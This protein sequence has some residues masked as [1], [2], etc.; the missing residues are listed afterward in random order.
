M[1]SPAILTVPQGGRHHSSHFTD[2]ET[3]KLGILLQVSQ[4]E[5]GKFKLFILESIVITTVWFC[6]SW[7]YLGHHRFWCRSSLNVY[8][9]STYFFIFV[10]ND[11]TCTKPK[12]HFVS[13]T[14]PVQHS[15]LATDTLLSLHSLK[16]ARRDCAPRK[17][18]SQMEGREA[19]R[20]IHDGKKT[21]WFERFRVIF[22][23]GPVLLRLEA[24][25]KTN[26]H[27]PSTRIRPTLT[28][29]YSG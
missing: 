20:W 9:D 12:Y 15:C 13:L 1:Q 24:K 10:F 7:T 6:F 22:E 29:S 8:L 3:E 28:C 25:T 14:V 27:L 16:K 4:L 18:G 21:S 5:S 23:N 19:A 2:E 26:P 17:E 11:P